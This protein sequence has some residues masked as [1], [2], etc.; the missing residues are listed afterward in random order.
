MIRSIDK[1]AIC[2]AK[3]QGIENPE[4]YILHQYVLGT[5]ANRLPVPLEDD[6][7]TA[8]V[9]MLYPEEQLEQ[10][11]ILP[12]SGGVFGTVKAIF[13]AFGFAKTKEE[14]KEEE[15]IST[16]IARKKRGKGLYG[17]E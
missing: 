6:E 13:R 16:S 1:C 10:T 3:E 7:L 2:V 4:D 9:L 17:S 15:P 8:G 12:A 14:V 11:G 5:D